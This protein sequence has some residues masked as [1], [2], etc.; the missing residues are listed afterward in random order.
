[1]RVEEERNRA[2]SGRS[3]AGS[4]GVDAG[5]RGTSRVGLRPR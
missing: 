3:Q 5:T 1:M 2:V 4:G